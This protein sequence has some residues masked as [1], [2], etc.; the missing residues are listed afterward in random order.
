MTNSLRNSF[1]RI[2]YII[3]HLGQTGVNNVVLD[4]VKVMNAHGH[5]CD[6]FYLETVKDTMTYPCGTIKLKSLW[7]KFDFDSFDVVHSHGLKP[8]LYV[9]INKP[10]RTNTLFVSTLH[11]Y[12]FQDFKDL[13]GTWK[14]FLFGC[15]FLITKIRHGKI[16]AL[17]NDMEKY[18]SKY[19]GRKRLTYAYNTRILDRTRVL[20]DVERSELMRFRS[21][22][23]LIGMNCVLLFRKGVDIMIKALSHLPDKYKLFIVGDGP[24]RRLFVDMVDKY[25]LGYRVFFAGKRNDA[26]RYLSLYDIYA[27][28]SRSEGF[29][30]ALLEAASYGCK[31]VCS[32]LPVIKETFID[33]E[34]SMF[35]L[36]DENDLT[37]AVL[38]VDNGMKLSENIERKF[39]KSYSSSA[40]YDKYYNIYTRQL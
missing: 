15:L 10:L 8:D 1:M 36:P 33:K 20:T 37:K 18:Y 2:A 27:L 5:E 22:G 9:M 38:R 19:Y 6:V 40:F 34:V 32:D 4:L 7:D 14:G 24:C 25:E 39:E 12:V 23:V 11:C 17:S 30:L 28:P 26:Y 35:H 21:D 13:Y 29:P 3:T 16:V 31:V